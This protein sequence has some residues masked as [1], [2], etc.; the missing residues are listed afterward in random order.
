M[1][2]DSPFVYLTQKG[3]SPSG[4][5]LRDMH[6]RQ[7]SVICR[8][9]KSQPNCVNASRLH[10]TDHCPSRPSGGLRNEVLFAEPFNV[11]KGVGERSLYGTGFDAAHALAVH[12]THK[13]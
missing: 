4:E 9:E 5:R 1:Q 2:W 8:R 7:E 3:Q 10:P 6:A 12:L 11:F 13:N